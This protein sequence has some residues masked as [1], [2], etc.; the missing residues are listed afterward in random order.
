MENEEVNSGDRSAATAINVGVIGAGSWGTTV[1]AMTCA[2]TPT[3]LWARREELAADINERHLNGD[4]LPDHT[5]PDALRA[6]SDL[7]DVVAT[8][9]VI[10]MAVPSHGYREVARQVGRGQGDVGADF[11]A[12]IGARMGG[13]TQAVEPN[14]RRNVW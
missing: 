11:H 14:P 5:L 12:A 6:S 2:N 7:A 8:S 13:G 4:Y 1:A 10:V 3:R 9:D